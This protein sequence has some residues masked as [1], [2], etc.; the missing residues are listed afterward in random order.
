[1]LNEPLLSKRY[2]RELINY[3]QGRLTWL[4]PPPPSPFFRLLPSSL[5]HKEIRFNS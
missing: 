2:D 5:L 4:S 3:L 1:M